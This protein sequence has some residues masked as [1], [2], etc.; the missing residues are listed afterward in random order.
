MR[1]F[2]AA[3]VKAYPYY[4]LD[5]LSSG[6][7]R[8]VSGIWRSLRLDE[9]NMRF[10]FGDGTMFNAL[11]NYKYFAGTQCDGSVSQL[12]V[13]ASAEDQ[14]EVVGFLVLM[15]NELTLHFDNHEVMS[16]E[17]ANDARLPML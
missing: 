9:K 2:T 13:D 16:V 10:I 1:D 3:A 6:S 17:L 8:W 11:G 5:H 7:G 15:P 4:R 14:K 12:N